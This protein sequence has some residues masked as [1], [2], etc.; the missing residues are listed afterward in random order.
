MNRLWNIL[1]NKETGLIMS[2]VVILISQ[3][4]KKITL[5]EIKAIIQKHASEGKI[6]IKMP[7]EW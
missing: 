2:L 5:L 1:L 6:T 4:K 3:K 7:T